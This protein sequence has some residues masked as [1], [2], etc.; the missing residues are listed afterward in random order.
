MKKIKIEETNDTEVFSPYTGNCVTGKDGEIIEDDKS[1]FFV[2]S[3]MADSYAYISEQLSRLIVGEIENIDMDDLVAKIS[4][5]EGTLMEVDNGWNGINYY[6]F[7][8]PNN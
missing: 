4:H 1:L 8:D 2:Y 7:I 3:G 6:C 5:I